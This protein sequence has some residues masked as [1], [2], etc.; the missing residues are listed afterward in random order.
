M[1]PYS[2][3]THQLSTVDKRQRRHWMNNSWNPRVQ[4]IM[5]VESIM[6]SATAIRPGM[7]RKEPMITT[8]TRSHRIQDWNG[9]DDDEIHGMES[10]IS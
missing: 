8:T 2:H 10:L 4:Q 6:P 3:E 9:D 5:L 7:K 1:D